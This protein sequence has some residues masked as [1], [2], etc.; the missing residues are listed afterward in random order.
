MGDISKQYEGLTA[1]I[2]ERLPMKA[3][4]VREL[5]QIFRKDGYPITL[6]T[7]LTITDVNNSGDISGIMCVIEMEDKKHVL[8]CALSHLVFPRTEA[9]YAEI[10]E[11]QIK[12]AK[13]VR[14]LDSL[15][16]NEAN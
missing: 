6:K 13:R 7:E 9:L 1:K 10:A 12:R 16:M 14:R 4:P 8:V 2:K 3:F 15:G 5:T 11:Y